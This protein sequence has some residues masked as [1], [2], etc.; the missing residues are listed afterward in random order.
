MFDLLP[1]VH[2]DKFDVTIRLPHLFK[3]LLDLYF[4]T[5]PSWINEK[6]ILEITFCF[7]LRVSEARES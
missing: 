1:L 4:F 3:N 2:E 5:I 6:L 7:I